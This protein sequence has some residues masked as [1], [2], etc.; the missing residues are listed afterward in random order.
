M[1]RATTP[2]RGVFAIPPTPFLASSDLD[3]R[4]LRSIIRFCLK[5][6]VHGIVA[7]VSA[8][9]FPFLSDEERL[10]VVETV[11]DEV[12]G[13]VPVVVGVTGSCLE[14]ALIF[15]KHACRVGADAIIAMPPH[16]QKAGPGVIHDYYEAI[17]A[18]A[19]RPVF[20]QNQVPPIG[21]PMTPRFMAD[22]INEIEWLDYVKEEC[23]PAGHNITAI[24]NLTR[25]KLK[26]V[27]GGMAGRYLLD[28]YRRGACGTMPACEI[29]DVHVHL[30]NLLE[31]ADYAGARGVFNAM[32]PLLN[33]EATYGTMIYKHVLARRGVI[34]STGARDPGHQPLDEFDM[35]ELD[36]ILADLKPL[37][38]S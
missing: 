26:G 12:R 34:D 3:L 19:Q 33:M 14:H 7:P 36:A 35:E 16:I 30:W 17:A 6:G 18:A 21:T 29:A 5:G 2:M 37:F 28:E 22:M 8:S 23:W 27:M 4:G 32:L 24:L 10:E 20:I 11:V 13:T 38:R 9:E 15:T 1:D 25:S 31:K